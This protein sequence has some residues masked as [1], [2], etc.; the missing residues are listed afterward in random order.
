MTDFSSGQIRHP[1]NM[2]EMILKCKGPIH[3]EKWDN[4][5]K[6]NE[7]EMFYLTNDFPPPPH[8]ILI[9][10]ILDNYFF[11]QHK[12]V[13]AH[14]ITHSEKYD[15]LKI[16]DKMYDTNSIKIDFSNSYVTRDTFLILVANI[17]TDKIY[18]YFD[19]TELRKELEY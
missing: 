4:A 14:L 5:E 13:L 3:A 19:M 7:F 17:K 12:Y 10:R 8:Y 16:S 9:E 1:I 2:P 11:P 15:N 18:G 6:T